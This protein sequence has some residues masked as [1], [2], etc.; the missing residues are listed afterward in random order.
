MHGELNSI[1]RT[2][3]NSEVKYCMPIIS[4]LGMWEQAD[5]SH[6]GLLA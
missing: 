1:F 2:H 5:T 4:L 3:V 6:Y